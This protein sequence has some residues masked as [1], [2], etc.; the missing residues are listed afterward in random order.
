[1]KRKK[2]I[3]IFVPGTMASRLAAPSGNMVWDIDS[4]DIMKIFFN[5]KPENRQD[6]LLTDPPLS[7]PEKYPDYLRDAFKKYPYALDRGWHTISWKYYG[8]LLESLD[9]WTAPAR[10]FIDVQI[11]AFGYNWLQSSEISGGELNVMLTNLVT[12]AK[13]SSEDVTASCY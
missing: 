11:Y 3:V 7:I 12:H 5:R 8:A 4:N 1:M 6:L 2:F 9:S 13:E 10:Y